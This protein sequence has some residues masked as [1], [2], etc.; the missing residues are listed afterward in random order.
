MPKIV[1]GLT[2]GIASGKSTVLEIF[3]R[4]GAHVLDCDK[5]AREAVKKGKPALSKI[6]RKFG[7]KVIKKDGSLNRPALAKL[8]F[9]DFR[10][11]KALE[12]IVHP[13]VKQEVFRRL[14]K[15][16]NG[17][18]IVDVPLLFEAGWQHYFDK[19]IVVWA[20]RKAQIARLAGRN[21]LAG[22]Q[23]A[24]RIA[25]QMPLS[26]KKKLADFTVDNSEKKARAAT[27]A[28]HIYGRLLTLVTKA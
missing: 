3:R 6:R 16:K 7:P 12:A 27:Q 10:K 17:V 14:K 20:P 15:I 25:A 18:V 4:K 13:Q 1:A 28:R 26:K 8:V 24:D 5:M 9:A 11:R 22:S 21:G 2:G 19:N 23:A